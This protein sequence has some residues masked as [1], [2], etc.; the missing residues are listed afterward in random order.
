LRAREI[1]GAIGHKRR[2]NVAVLASTALLVFGLNGCQTESTQTGP[3]A[4]Q[5]PATIQ[6]D[7][8]VGRWGLASY[9]NEADR[10]R[11]ITA[12]RGQCGQPYVI[13]KGQSGGVVMLLAD[14][15]K[16]Q[17]LFLK[18]A[19]G[20]KNFIGPTGPAGDAQDREIVSFDKSVVVMNWVDPEVAGRYG[21]MVLV[22]CMKA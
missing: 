8:L 19:Q 1:A 9:H 2:R 6:A 4:S 12:A 15:P 21:T 3:V 11:T 18:G 5:I 22:R 13:T 17:E 10:A 16:P 14:D 20:G 7:A